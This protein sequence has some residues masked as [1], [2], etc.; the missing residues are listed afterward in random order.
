MRFSSPA[1]EVSGLQ[2]P[3]PM[4]AGA[5]SMTTLLMALVVAVEGAPRFKVWAGCYNN[6][7]ALPHER[8]KP[9]VETK[10]ALHMAHPS[11]IDGIA[12]AAL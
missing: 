6:G 4:I 1:S 2:P 7:A 9:I 12:C 10:R 11:M 3:S 5:V 8:R